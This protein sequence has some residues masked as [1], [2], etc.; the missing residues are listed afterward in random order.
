[1]GSNNKFGWSQTPATTPQGKS[2]YPNTLPN[3]AQTVQREPNAVL[4]FQQFTSELARNHPFAKPFWGLKPPTGV[5]IP[6]LRQI[7]LLVRFADGFTAEHEAG[8]VV[9]PYS[10]A[11]P[12]WDRHK[13][14]SIG[15]FWLWQ[16]LLIQLR[17][18]AHNSLHI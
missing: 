5:R 8:E 2:L 18:F 14:I 12:D 9:E 11:C 15:H 10:Q 4:S 17:F 16:L 1:M 6:P 13:A 7:S 3:R